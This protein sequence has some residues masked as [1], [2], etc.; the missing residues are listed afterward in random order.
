MARRGGAVT[1]YLERIDLCAY[2]RVSRGAY[3]FLTRE[4]RRSSQLGLSLLLVERCGADLTRVTPRWVSRGS[5]IVAGM[6]SARH[7]RQPGANANHLRRK[8]RTPTC[9]I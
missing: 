6:A 5:E 8:R 1:H 4:N 2:W 7:R 3:D 9:R